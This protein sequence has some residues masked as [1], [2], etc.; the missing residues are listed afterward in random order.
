MV[1]FLLLLVSVGAWS[2]EVHRDTMVGN[3]W[4]EWIRKPTR[5]VPDTSPIRIVPLDG[6]Y[7]L[8]MWP[9]KLSWVSSERLAVVH[10]LR[11]GV[12]AELYDTAARA[13]VAGL[14]YFFPDDG[15]SEKSHAS[16]LRRVR[17]G[18]IG[19]W[20]VSFLGML[21]NETE[22]H[23]PTVPM[24]FELDTMLGVKR[25]VKDTMWYGRVYPAKGTDPY[26]SYPFI[27]RGYGH[28]YDAESFDGNVC[29]IMSDT[30]WK[31]WWFVLYTDDLATKAVVRN[32]PLP[33]TVSIRDSLGRD[34]TCQLVVMPFAVRASR[35]GIA[36]RSVT[37]DS[38][39]VIVLFRGENFD[40]IRAIRLPR[41]DLD[42]VGVRVSGSLRELEYFV[43]DGYVIDAAMRGNRFVLSKVWENGKVEWEQY[44]VNQVLAG[45]RSL[46]QD[47]MY[48]R[49]QAV[50]VGWLVSFGSLLEVGALVC[51]P[52]QWSGE[53]HWLLSHR[54]S[55]SVDRWGQL[56]DGRC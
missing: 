48:Y 11:Y 39:R 40:D 14:Y 34:T 26:S 15:W 9:S 33:F 56:R 41:A 21:G 29:Y 18:G 3:I 4:L 37:S 17:T 20:G 25:I 1:A 32:Y 23:I 43:E 55:E 50:A 2:Q 54:G 38:E 10:P 35:M 6:N 5:L 27:W 7:K 53:G 8:W 42:F 49:P 52:S 22:L 24:F 46:A 31:R 12:V 51:C 30:S 16:Q 19:L 28:V 13:Q 36:A 47:Y 45:A 44:P